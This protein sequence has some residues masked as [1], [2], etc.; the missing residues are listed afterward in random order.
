[1]HNGRDFL[2]SLATHKFYLMVSRAFKLKQ[3]KPRKPDILKRGTEASRGASKS[4]SHPQRQQLL[5]PKN[6][7]FIPKGLIS[8]LALLTIPRLTPANWNGKKSRTANFCGVSPCRRKTR[9]GKHPAG[10]SI[11][12][13]RKPNFYGGSRALGAIQLMRCDAG[14]FAPS[15]L[16]FVSELLVRS[17]NNLFK[18]A[19]RN[20]WFAL[21]CPEKTL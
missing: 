11:Y 3:Q 10:L 13:T 14:N 16:I 1:M 9:R 21:T 4:S 2:S 17:P 19:T 8:Y 15:P 6:R 7:A 20:V 18:Q 5:T 12:Y